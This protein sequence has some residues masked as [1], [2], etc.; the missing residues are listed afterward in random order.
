MTSGKGRRHRILGLTALLVS[1]LL[2]LLPG[3][4]AN[5]VAAGR[6]ASPRVTAVQPPGFLEVRDDGWL[7][8][9]E[10]TDRSF[11]GHRIGGGWDRTSLVALLGTDGSFVEVKGDALRLWQVDLTGGANTLTFLGSVMGGWQ[12]ARLIAGVGDAT[13]DGIPDFVEVD[14]RGN[15]VVWRRDGNGFAYGGIEGYGWQN[16]RQIAGVAVKQFV[17]IKTNGE[18][19]SWRLSDHNPTEPWWATGGFTMGGWNNV[20]L[21]GPDG[22]T[23]SFVSVRFDTQLVRWTSSANTFRPSYFDRGWQN[24]RL[25]G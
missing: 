25:L 7:W 11:T 16:A 24:A 18:L 2:A 12:N 1:A 9:Y 21:L 5:A 13:Y 19:W 14:N 20:R 4:P 6:A 15:L 22:L 8:Y 3:V 23:D 17:E 10:R